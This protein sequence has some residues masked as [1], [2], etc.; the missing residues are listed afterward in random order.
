MQNSADATGNNHKLNLNNSCIGFDIDQIWFAVIMPFSAVRPVSS[1]LVQTICIWFIIILFLRFLLIAINWTVQCGFLKPWR[2][3][4][5]N[6]WSCRSNITDMVM[7]INPEENPFW[8]LRLARAHILRIQPF[9]QDY[10]E[11]VLQEIS[12]LI[13]IIA[14]SLTGE[15]FLTAVVPKVSTFICVECGIQENPRRKIV[16]QLI[17]FIVCRPTL[18][19]TILIAIFTFCVFIIMFV[20]YFS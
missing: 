13:S 12:W 6:H 14:D 5:L 15:T 1:L 8:N 11:R 7:K 10:L 4:T 20:Y 3:T 9:F 18:V 19:R 16:S 17:L 2:K